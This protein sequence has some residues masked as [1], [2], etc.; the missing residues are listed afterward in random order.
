MRFLKEHLT[1]HYEW[2][3]MGDDSRFTGDATRRSFDRFN[4]E[5]L[6][7]MINLYLSMFKTATIEDGQKI[8]DFIA[9]QL[10]FKNESEISVLSHLKESNVIED[11]K[12][13]PG[14]GEYIH[15]SNLEAQNLN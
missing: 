3:S 6:L 10:P 9:N 2:E 8:E 14:G 7:F 12:K 1:G 4:G 11:A 15:F 5:Q 13:A